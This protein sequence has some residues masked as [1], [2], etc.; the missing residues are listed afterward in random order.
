MESSNSPTAHPEPPEWMQPSEPELADGAR[1]RVQGIVKR[2]A[3]RF[4]LLSMNCKRSRTDFKEGKDKGTARVMPSAT[5]NDT[6]SVEFNDKRNIEES[7]GQVDL[8]R[9]AIVYENQRGYGP[10]VPVYLHR[11]LLPRDPPPFTLPNPGDSTPSSKRPG[12]IPNVTLQTY[13]LPDPTWRWVSKSWLVDMRGDGDV[14]HDGFEYN[15]FFRRRHWRARVGWLSTGG[16]VRRRRWVRLMMHPSDARL[17]AE[18]ATESGHEDTGDSATAAS[19]Q[20]IDVP[21]WR[22]NSGDWE[23]LR[24]FFKRIGRD[25]PKIDLW[26]EWLSDLIG[27]RAIAQSPRKQWTEDDETDSAD[28]VMEAERQMSSERPRREWVVAVLREHGR[29]LGYCFV[30]PDSRAQLLDLFTLARLVQNDSP[31]ANMLGDQLLQP[32]DFWSRRQSG[33][34]TCDSGTQGTDLGQPS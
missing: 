3:S 33:K 9:W 14:Q 28:L 24:W 21:I 10:V 8:F 30:Y 12:R 7:V 15:W 31:T 5:E 34:S 27:K 20:F 16:F 4:S 13:P 29:E 32:H 23:R 2:K 25:G 26:T 1:K 19:S 17:E 22:G 18:A 6:L 11:S